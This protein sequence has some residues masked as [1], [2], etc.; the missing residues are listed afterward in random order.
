MNYRILTQ[1]GESILTQNGLGYLV[2]DQIIPPISA[3]TEYTVCVICDGI[4]VEINPPHPVW[5]DGYGREV[6]QL[7]MVV[8]GGS[9]GLNN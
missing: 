5:T 3:G 8:I 9:N 1:N 7:N 4:A 6:T 2:Y